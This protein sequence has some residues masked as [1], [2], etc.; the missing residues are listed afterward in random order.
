MTVLGD[1]KR[2]MLAIK[3]SLGGHSSSLSSGT[4]FGELSEL[5]EG[6]YEE[7]S[8]RASAA[9]SVSPVRVQ[10]FGSL[11]H[12]CSILLLAAEVAL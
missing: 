5:L 12:L 6:S 1:R 9:V 3:K 11:S 2:V 10:M 4:S 8:P 7:R